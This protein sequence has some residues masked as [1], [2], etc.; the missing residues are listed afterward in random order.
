MVVTQWINKGMSGRVS[1]QKNEFVTTSS[2]QIGLILR[3]LALEKKFKTRDE[4]HEIHE[5]PLVVLH[6]HCFHLILF[7][8]PPSH[9]V[10]LCSQISAR[11]R[12][13]R[14]RRRSLSRRM[15]TP[16]N[17]STC[18]DTRQPSCCSLCRSPF[19][20]VVVPD[21]CSRCGTFKR[22]LARAFDPCHCPFFQLSCLSRA[23]RFFLIDYG[24][25]LISGGLYVGR[26]A[27]SHSCIA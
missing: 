2:I 18:S 22:L 7:S 6:K 19:P 11:R 5:A 17:R 27:T 26:E 4:P 16:Q 25:P 15:R 3:A 23:R 24:W 12:G 13:R 8:S 9:V 1:L 20:V 21:A 14:W 10:W